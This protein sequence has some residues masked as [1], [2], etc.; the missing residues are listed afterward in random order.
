[1]ECDR[2]SDDF[3]PQSELIRR[4]RREAAGGRPAFSPD[5]QSRIVTAVAD[6]G[7]RGSRRFTRRAAAWAGVCCVLLGV[8]GGLWL[9]AKPTTPP[10]EPAMAATAAAIEGAGEWPPIDQMPLLDEIG[11]E[12]LT[13]TAAIVAEAVGLPQWNELADAGRIARSMTFPVPFP[14]PFPETSPGR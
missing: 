5:L 9:T 13:G 12:L 8:G 10:I 7:R 6:R 1:M 4:L 11:S 14:V 3:E 2:G